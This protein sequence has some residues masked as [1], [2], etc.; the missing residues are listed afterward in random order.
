MDLEQ[1]QQDFE[2][3]ALKYS[4]THARLTTPSLEVHLS[5]GE[6]YSKLRVVTDNYGHKRKHPVPEDATITPEALTSFI[7]TTDTEDRAYWVA[8]HKALRANRTPEQIA[9]D[10]ARQKTYQ[11]GYQ[12]IKRQ[13]ERDAREAQLEREMGDTRG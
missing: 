1:L 13:G 5:I 10:K 2:T 12:R 3:F 8:K 9:R 4:I 11:R 7:E 6:P